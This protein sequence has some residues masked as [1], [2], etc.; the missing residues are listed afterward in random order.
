MTCL[1]GILLVVQ[2]LCVNVQAQTSVRMQPT[3][4]TEGVEFF[5]TWLVN[6]E[7]SDLM[8][9][10]LLLTSKYKA[11][12]VVEN[13]G[14]SNISLRY[15]DES[16]QKDV[17]GVNNVT[18]T[19]DKDVEVHVGSSKSYVL[20][21]SGSAQNKGLRVYSTNG[22]P[23]SM[24]VVH[25]YEDGHKNGSALDG[26]VVLPR[27]ALGREYVI[28]T[29]NSD[30][31]GTEFIIEATEDGTNIQIQLTDTASG[32]GEWRQPIKKTLN[33]KQV[34]LVTSVS[35]KSGVYSDLSGTTICSDK[36]IA[37]YQGNKATS[38]P[39]VLAYSTGHLYEQALP[40]DKW[41][42]EFVVPMT[43]SGTSHN[44][45]NITA[46]KKS[47]VTI[48]TQSVSID[49]DSTY[50]M[51]LY[52]KD[53]GNKP[54]FVK[55]DNPVQVMLYTTS[56]SENVVGTEWMGTPSSTVINPLSQLTDSTTFSMVHFLRA[57]ADVPLHSQRARR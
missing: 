54:L 32:I 6:N 50:R 9:V 31:K 56:A 35:N 2:S 3:T 23:F 11:N 24:T 57:T 46:F 37:V 13:Y 10:R 39:D 1:V 45:L 7:I 19:P 27:E 4:T 30:T 22:L 40:V 38:I 15:W 5:T 52:A 44:V 20:N 51:D 14:G 55:S 33:R 53:Y 18:L 26:T 42:T 49:A 41:G 16:Q 36:P 34:F 8:G 12:V 21:T 25:K 29:N 48:G 43:Q 17:T 28:Q 47:K